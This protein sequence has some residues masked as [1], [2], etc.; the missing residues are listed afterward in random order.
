MNLGG[1]VVALEVQRV[2]TNS[3]PTFPNHNV[4][5]C[6]VLKVSMEVLE[7]CDSALEE[8]EVPQNSALNLMVLLRLLLVF[9][10]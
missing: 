5:P 8:S 10:P 7:D 3:H 9:V 4:R 6:K 1:F 2:S